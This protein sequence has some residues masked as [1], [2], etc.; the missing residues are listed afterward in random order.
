MNTGIISREKK[1]GFTLLEL[2]IVIAIIAIL[3]VA[4]ILVINPAETLRKSR[5]AQR[6]SDMNTM[7]TALGLY[8]TS[9]TTPYLG[10]VTANTACKAT[11]TTAYGTT[12][13]TVKLF[14]SL[15]TGAGTIS[16]TILDGSSITTPAS[17]V[18]T[19][20]L[21]DGTGWIPVNFDTLTGGSPISNLPVDPT[22]ALVSPDTVSSITSASLMYRYACSITPL[23]FEIDAPL[24]SITY[25]QTENKLTSDG[26]NN[27]N[28]Y[29]VGT[30]LKILGAG[31]D[32]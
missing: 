14:Y 3:S 17:Q 30:N 26:G 29:E 2:L 22:N 15:P 1:G 8:L 27:S 21:T 5:D 6:I 13:A 25:T 20:S 32:F 12:G 31:T 18:A 19:P 24:E 4:L 16:D 28:F 9:T 11:P 23:A 10:S 7:K